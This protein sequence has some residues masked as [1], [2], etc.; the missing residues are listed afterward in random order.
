MAYA[1]IDVSSLRVEPRIPT[2]NDVFLGG[3]YFAD[4]NDAATSEETLDRIG[5]MKYTIELKG[6][7]TT[8]LYTGKGTTRLILVKGRSSTISS[9]T[10]LYVEYPGRIFSCPEDGN[11]QQQCISIDF[12]TNGGSSDAKGYW[13]IKKSGIRFLPDNQLWSKQ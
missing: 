1:A 13:D 8:A 2:S 6:L 7:G 12:S 3:P 4:D 9:Q 10:D 11:Q 5:R